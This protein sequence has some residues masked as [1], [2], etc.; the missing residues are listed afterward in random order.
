MKTILVVPPFTQINTTYPSV[1]QLS[2]YLNSL[3]YDALS[4]DLSLNVILRIFSKEG[5][6]RLFDEISVVDSGDHNIKR[7][8]LLKDQYINKADSVIRFLQGKDL[9]TAKQIIKDG[10][11]PQGESFINDTDERKLFGELGELD[12]AK[13]HASLFM[14][15]IVKLIQ[16]TIA[17]SFGLSRYAERLSSSTAEFK[18]I[19]TELNK[20]LNFI[21]KLII[22]ETN[23]FVEEEQPDVI[24]YSIA[25]PG[26]LLGALISASYIKKNWPDKKIVFG[27]GYINTE[28]RELKD[29]SIFKYTDYITLDDGELPL[30]NLLKNL[31]GRSDEKWVRTFVCRNNKVEY[32]NT[33]NVQILK[34]DELTV[35]SINGISPGEY[36]SMLE[37]ANPM[38]RLWSDGYWNKLTLAHGCYWHKCTFCDTTLDYIK[39]YSPARAKT[40]VDWMEDL[41]Q[42]TNIRSFHFTDEAAPPS[43]LKEVAIEILNRKLSVVWWGNIRFEK[44]FT[45]DLCR[46]LNA[47]GCIAVSGGIEVA[48]ERLLKLIEKGITIEQVSKVL[49]NFQSAGIMVHSYLMYGFPTQ[50]E[51]ETIDSLEIV[52]QF[53]ENGLIQ[54]G[55]WHQFALTIHSPIAQNTAKFNIEIKSP[56]NNIFANNDLKHQDYPGCDHT[57]FSKGLKKAIYNFMHGVGTD[58]QITGWFDIKV[59]QTKMNRNLI[60]KYLENNYLETP[61]ERSRSIWLAERPILNQIKKDVID[62]RILNNTLDGSW[63]MDSQTAIWINKTIGRILNQEIVLYSDWKTSFP[64]DEKMFN[65]FIHSETWNELRE[66][67]LLFV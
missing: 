46:L 38:H 59:P 14:D 24:G 54:S 60:S 57:K 30:I 29:S 31:T 20:E 5:L 49:D 52:R 66:N 16:K 18:T 4:I 44:S 67:V 45:S 34:H 63:E 26:N 17:P 48:D 13:H 37:M 7:M 11:L 1:L 56:L 9:D 62:F 39:R 27:G 2:G 35:P 23:K 3:G 21:D 8:I 51:Q 64:G 32:L 6:T 40:I 53:F 10:F 22:E 25:F 28:L 65:S 43:L 61:S 42:Q 33:A 12:K 55:F 36:I 19:E 15:D 58:W 50:T 47:S 41:I